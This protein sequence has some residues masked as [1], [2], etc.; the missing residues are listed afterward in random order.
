[1]A[2]RLL[3]GSLRVSEYVDADAFARGLPHSESAGVTAGRAVL[4]RLDEL[5][6]GRRKS[7]LQPENPRS[8]QGGISVPPGLPLAAKRGLRSGAG[9]GSGASRR[10]RG[11]RG[12]GSSSVP[13]GFA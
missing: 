3:V 1:M 2:A 11:T 9:G 7:I 6:A 8:D 10:S 13:L 5:A 12:N 4:R